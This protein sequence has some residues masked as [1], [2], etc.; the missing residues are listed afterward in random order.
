M[1]RSSLMRSAVARHSR[2]SDDDVKNF[3][4]VVRA[5]HLL[6][7]NTVRL[8]E[9]LIVNGGI[10]VSQKSVCVLFSLVFAALHGCPTVPVGHCSDS[11]QR[12]KKRSGSTKQENLSLKFPL[13]HCKSKAV[14]LQL[15]VVVL[16]VSS[17]H[18]TKRKREF[19]CQWQSY[20][21]R[22]ALGKTGSG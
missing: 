7:V 9:A 15:A 10:S 11:T 4:G 22:H 2:T 16:A 5:Q 6:E 13:N 21:V 17:L 8:R 20:M 19:H 1:Q 12:T 18:V 14:F 3:L